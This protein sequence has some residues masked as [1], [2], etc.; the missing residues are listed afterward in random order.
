[1][2]ERWEPSADDPER[3]FSDAAALERLSEMPEWM[4]MD[5]LLGEHADRILLALRQRGLDHTTTESLRA[6]LEAVEWL[7]YRPIALRR[8][9]D[10]RDKLLAAQ[11]KHTR[12]GREGVR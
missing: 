2:T 1:V 10:E 5:R 8:A 3:L 11:A 7:R 12:Q 4:V 9:V 6:E